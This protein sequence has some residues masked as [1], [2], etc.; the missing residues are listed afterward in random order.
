MVGEANQNVLSCWQCFYS[1][2]HFLLVYAPLPIVETLTGKRSNEIAF[3][4]VVVYVYGV[5]VCPMDGQNSYTDIHHCAFRDS[6]EKMLYYNNYLFAVYFLNI[7]CERIGHCTHSKGAYTH[8]GNSFYCVLLFFYSSIAVVD[9]LLLDHRF[10]NLYFGFVV[11]RFF[12][13]FF[14]YSF[15]HRAVVQNSQFA[16]RP[17]EM[18]LGIQSSNLQ[19][20][21]MFGSTICVK[22][23]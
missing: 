8:R 21:Q 11:L 5:C 2:K 16:I 14:S 9:C 6:A 15:V 13:F 3:F 7:D 22:W 20:N 10:Q 19:D 17:E 1:F 23:H 18:R 4:A 12:V